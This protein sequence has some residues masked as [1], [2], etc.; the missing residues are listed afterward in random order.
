MGVKRNFTY[1]SILTL[2]S[3]FFPL[4]TYPYVS[5]ILGVSGIGTVNFVDSIIEYAILISMMGIS[6]VGIR[7]IAAHKT[8]KARLSGT[9]SSLF[10]LNAASTAI[11]IG[12]VTVAMFT[13]PQLQPHKNLLSIGLCKLLMNLFL[14]EWLFIGLEDFAYI[15]KRALL[16]KC[17]YVAGI[18]IFIRDASDITHYYTL[19]VSSV[20]INALINIGYARKTVRF[21]LRNINVKPYLSKYFS[22]G[23]YKLVSSLYL[24]M[25]VAWL[26][27]ITDTIQVGYYTTATKLYTIIIALFTAF[28]S[29]MLPRLSSLL[30]EHKTDEYW[31]KIR[32]STEAVLFFSFPVITYCMVFGDRILLTLVG[33]GFE[34]A[35]LPFRLIIP[36]VLIIGMSQIFVIQILLPMKK[37]YKV[38]RNTTMGAV[39]AIV[40]NLSIVRYLGATGSAITWIC[41]EMIV[42]IAS[43]KTIQGFATFRIPYK[44]IL[45]Y[46]MAYMPLLVALVVIHG[47]DIF[48]NLPLVILTT[49]LTIAYSVFIQQKYL[50]S[51]IYKMLL[52]YTKLDRL[53]SK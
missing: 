37:D 27:F 40:I 2:S 18:F 11:A 50:A 17:L 36:L 31:Q 49:I 10:V 33:K 22:N 20:A 23:I 43:Y 21:S 52:Q 25:N 16:V 48:G 7:E 12:I 44:R 6:I 13:V 38:L 32:L 42:L 51:D 14:T 47:I 29:V 41:S 30:V 46:A 24:S 53:T 28:T 34:G 26:G 4:I 39:G 45:K 1:S 19:T 9:F 5:R 8:D 35:Y 3:Y 15:T